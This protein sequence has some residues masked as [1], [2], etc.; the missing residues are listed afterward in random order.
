MGTIRAQV[1]GTLMGTVTPIKARLRVAH[2]IPGIAARTGGPAAS[3]LGTALALNHAGVHVEVFTTDIGTAA[4]ARHITRLKP[5]DIDGPTD[6]PIHIARARQPLRLAYAPALRKELAQR[7]DEF[8]VIH[9][10][11]LFLYPQYAA[12]RVAYERRIP[13]VVSPRG[14]LDPYLRR[15]GRIRKA[16]TD[17]VWQRQ[18]LNHAAALHLTADKEVELIAGIAPKVRRCVIPN[19]VDWRTYADLPDPRTFTSKYLSGQ[20]PPIV[21]YLGRISHKK[22]ID[23]LIAAFARIAPSH[24][25]A[26]LVI[27]GPDDEGLTPQLQKAATQFGVSGRTTFIGH[28][29]GKEKLAALAAATVWVLPS[30]TENFG[31]AAVEALAAGVPV[32]M[33][34]GVNISAELGELGAC[35]VCEPEPGALATEISALLE[36]PDRRSALA[37]AGRRAARRFSPEIVAAQMTSLYESVLRSMSDSR[38]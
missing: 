18:M 32:I 29:A 28:L 36:H 5:E 21:M 33:S 38:G 15:R 31:V 20:S 9:I 14:A 11:S 16:L 35:I 10:H 30:A 34:P 2:V 23:V 12:Y 26:A 24:P 37:T 27:I 17:L 3:V 13:Y 19:P 6:F 4:S 25:N 22:R 1:L 7:A 8:D